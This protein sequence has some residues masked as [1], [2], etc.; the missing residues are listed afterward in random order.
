[1]ARAIEA[2]ELAGE[3]LANG[4][5]GEATA[6]EL[7]ALQRSG[8]DAWQR[9]L[10]ANL[11]LVQS[12][13]S[14]EA[15]RS[16]AAPDELF[17]EGF[18][19]LTEALLRWDCAAGYRFST[20]ASQWIR[21]RVR[22]AAVEQRVPASTRTALRARGVRGL[23]DDLT[24]ELR[25]Q[26]TA[27]E[28][29]ELLGRSERWVGRMLWLP[30]WM[31]LDAESVAVEP[32]PDDEDD[33]RALLPE[34]PDVEARVVRAR[35]GLDGDAALRQGPAARALGMSVSTLRRHE[36]RALR[37]LRGWLLADRAA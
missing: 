19:G 7:R 9:F 3:L 30:T 14:Q 12:I 10:L 13:A 11:R 5:H 15:R 21:R 34:L 37:R 20:Y 4:D 35:F 36:A 33:V 22:D 6:T 17:Q 2:G 31:P 1:M 8:R 27:S 32:A 28:L 26:V 29:A 24:G 18:L 16:P 25:R 23:A